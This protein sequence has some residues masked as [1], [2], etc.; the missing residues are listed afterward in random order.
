MK[1]PICRHSNALLPKGLNQIGGG[2]FWVLT[3][4]PALDFKAKVLEIDVFVFFCFGVRLVLFVEAGVGGGVV[5]AGL[6]CCEGNLC[7]NNQALV[8][9]S[10]F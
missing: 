4:S 5:V 7:L 10:A 6:G 1:A 2:A 8:L 3:V 9:Q